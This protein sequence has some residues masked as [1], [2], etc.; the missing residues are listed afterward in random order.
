MDWFNSL[1]TGVW[2]QFLDVLNYPFDPSQRIY[3]PFLA[4]SF[5]IAAVLYMRSPAFTKDVRPGRRGLLGLFSFIFPRKVWSHPSAWV[6]VRYFIPHQLVRLLIYVNFSILVISLSSNSIVVGLQELAGVSSLS[7][8]SPSNIPLGI[9]YAVVAIIV[10]DFNAF[11]IHYL[12]H[13]IPVLWEF[14]KVHHSASV[15][16]PLSNYREHPVDNFS[17]ALMNGLVIGLMAGIVQFFFA[18][19][20]TDIYIAA[21]GLSILRFGFNAVGYNLR[22]S[23]IWLRWPGFLGYVVGCP[24]HHQIHHSCKPEHIDRNFAFILPVWDL[25]FG[26]FY[27]PKE[28]EELLIGLGD[29]TEGDYKSFISIYML[30]FK[31]LYRSRMTQANGERKVP[32]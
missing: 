18:V 7:V 20:A 12:Q 16:H 26:T 4:S 29:G 21:I 28:E 14:H 9:C 15:L 31:N 5:V 19:K 25:M 24:A 30:P 32:D 27:L 1:I 11:Y 10:I 13:K 22:H 17:Y 6:D 2:L 8:V 3:I 23:H